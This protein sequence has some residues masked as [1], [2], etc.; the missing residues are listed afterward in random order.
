M[1]K[2]RN[3]R[4]KGTRNERMKKTRNERIKGTRNE[5][6]KKTRNERIKGKRNERMKKTRNERMKKMVSFLSSIKANTCHSSFQSHCIKNKSNCIKLIVSQMNPKILSIVFFSC[7]VHSSFANHATSMRTGGGGQ[8]QQ[9]PQV[10]GHQGE[11]TATSSSLAIV[12]AR[13]VATRIGTSTWSRSAGRTSIPTPSGNSSAADRDSSHA[14]SSSSSGSRR[15]TGAT[16]SNGSRCSGTD[17]PDSAI[18]AEPGPE[19]CQQTI[20]YCS[21]TCT[22]FETIVGLT[23]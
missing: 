4:I 6:M 14:S 12:A 15:S 21:T 19:P 10:C 17:C 1:K 20:G 2:T 16:G 22:S 13:N 5:R 18:A 9:Q 11:P 7:L 8:Q 23:N 3:E